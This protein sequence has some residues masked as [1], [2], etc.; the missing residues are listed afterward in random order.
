MKTVNNIDSVSGLRESFKE[1]GK[2]IYILF[3]I[4]NQVDNSSIANEESDKI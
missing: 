1:T 4:R 2:K 3:R